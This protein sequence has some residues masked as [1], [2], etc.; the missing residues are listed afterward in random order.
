MFDHAERHIHELAYS[1]NT[2]AYIRRWWRAVQNKSGIKISGKIILTNYNPSQIR[3]KFVSASAACCSDYSTA[4]SVSDLR[5]SCVGTKVINV[6]LLTE[7]GECQFILW[8]HW[9]KGARHRNKLVHTSQTKPRPN[10]APTLC[11]RLRRWHRVGPVLNRQIYPVVKSMETLL[12]QQSPHS[13]C[14]CQRHNVW[15]VV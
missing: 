5:Q 15:M 10:T 6:S 1:P 7:H 3:P 13:R 2:V 9:L 8:G 4:T 12:M 11:Q 14:E